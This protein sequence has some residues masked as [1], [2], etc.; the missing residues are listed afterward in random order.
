MIAQSKHIGKNSGYPMKELHLSPESVAKYILLKAAE[1]GELTTP[2][3]LQ[4]LVY[5]SYVRSLVNGFKLFDE[6]IEAW[7]NGP[8]VP[9]LYQAL[10]KYGY[11]PIDQKY[12]LSVKDTIQDEL[13][14][15]L[16]YLDEA[17]ETY[18]PRTAFELVAITHLD[19]AW[20]KARAG[21]QTTERSNTPI[22]DELIL[23]AYSV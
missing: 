11:N 21:K 12:Y 23:A 20:S 1:D 19:G 4:K 9:S 2:L 6:P 3:K 8:V 16:P 17:L 10:K 18:S 7:P 13:K 15:A 5:L 22:T 14:E